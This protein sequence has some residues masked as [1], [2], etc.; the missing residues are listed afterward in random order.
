MII[1]NKGINL[2]D[3]RIKHIQFEGLDED[4][5]GTR[6]GASI[7]KEK[8]S[9]E[10]GDVLIAFKMNGQDIP[11]DHGYPLRV[12]VPGNTNYTIMLNM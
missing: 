1:V 8:V 12:V 11:L 6:Y 3:E 5:T 7:P 2:G 10:L 9:S 4:P